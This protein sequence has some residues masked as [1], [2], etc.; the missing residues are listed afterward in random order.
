M[1]V[2][3]RA[4][5]ATRADL[6]L[7]VLSVFSVAVAFVC[8]AA[9][10]MVVV[11]IDAV[12]QR[13]EQSGRASVYLRPDVDAE[14]VEKVRRALLASPGVEQVRFV[15]SEEARTDVIGQSGDAALAA[16][17]PEAFP[18]SLEFDLRDAAA[19]ER[20]KKL[21]GQLE[22]LPYVDAVETYEEWG[23][24]LQNLLSGGV[25][26][27]LLLLG[28]VLLAVVSV[29]SST[30]RMALQRRSAEVEVLKMVGATDGYVRGPFV[31]EGAMQ[32][33][34]GAAA[35]IGILGCLHMIIRRSFDGALGTLL[36]ASPMFLPWLACLSLV[37]LGA[38]IGA[39]TAAVSLRRP[40]VGDL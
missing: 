24:R 1:K 28:V 20:L 4:W 14:Q 25:S 12:R 5:R 36:G 38:M 19:A 8:L 15:S 16:L 11:N 27:A 34:L 22:S 31:V 2:I 21:A 17:P 29:V 23:D 3:E 37:A 30:M 6:K 10:L 40:M 18:A 13:W 39:I 35:A 7:H 26:A 32:G 33:A 9:A